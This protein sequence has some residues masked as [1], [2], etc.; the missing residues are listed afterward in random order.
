MVSSELPEIMGMSD[1][2]YVFK[3]G[4]IEREF[5]NSSA[6]TDVELL[7]HAIIGAGEAK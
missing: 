6:M 3:D 5:R 7:N 1:R 4:G 2:I